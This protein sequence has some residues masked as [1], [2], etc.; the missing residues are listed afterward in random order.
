[1]SFELIRSKCPLASGPVGRALSLREC[2][3]FPPRALSLSLLYK[4]LKIASGH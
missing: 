3:R 1:M 2:L 4:L